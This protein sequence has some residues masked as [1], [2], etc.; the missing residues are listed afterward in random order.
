M[1]HKTDCCTRRVNLGV[2]KKIVMTEKQGQKEEHPDVVV[3]WWSAVEVGVGKRRRIGR[4]AFPQ[5]S[6]ESSEQLSAVRRSRILAPMALAASGLF[7]P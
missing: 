6:N 1:A 4:K 2:T 3:A 7:V 5:F